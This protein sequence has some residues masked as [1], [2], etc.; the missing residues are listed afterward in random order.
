MVR[1][2]FRTHHDQIEPPRDV[3]VIARPGAGDAD[4]AE[5]TRE[6]GSALRID[7]SQ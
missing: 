3:V 4:Y 1:E 2:F 5:V 7:A 6:L